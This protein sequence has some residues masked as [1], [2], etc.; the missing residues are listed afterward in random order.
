M[1]RELQ[2]FKKR[3]QSKAGLI[4]VIAVVALIV[5]CGGVAGVVFSTKTV[6]NVV[7]ESNIFL[8]VS[9]TGNDLVV[10]IYDQGNCR[11]LQ[12]IILAIDGYTMPAGI[13]TKSLTSNFPQTVVYSGMAGGITGDRQVSIKG[14]FMDS[15]TST[16]WIGTVRFT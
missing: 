15:S 16:V 9:V 13:A 1:A 8:S 3:K 5:L 6:D 10:Q 4:V 11:D 12:H 2:S 7:G 14:I